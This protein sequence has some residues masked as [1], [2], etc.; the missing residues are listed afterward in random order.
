VK[1]IKVLLASGEGQNYFDILDDVP[2][3]E[4]VRASTRD[5]ILE[6]V[7]DVEVF[8]GPPSSELLAA[9]KALR[10]I[11]TP[12]AGVDVLMRLPE[13][14]ENDIVMTN[15]RGAHGPSIAEH[16]FALLLSLTRAIPACLE[17]QKQKHWG[18]GES[19]RALHEIKGSTLGIVGFGAIG[20]NVAQRATAFEMAILAVDAQPVVGPPLVDEVWP[21]SRLHELLAQSDVV[22]IAAPFT[23]ETRHLI[24]AAA[25][26]QMRSDAYLIAVSRG[27]IV[28][29]AALIEALRAGR[30]AGVG[31]DVSEQEPLSPESP[32][33]DFPNVII[34]PHVAGASA[35]KERR[36]VEIFRENLI[37]YTNGD[38]L[39]NLV[40]KRLG[41]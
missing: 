5:E 32:L 21:V 3:I 40:D 37:R 39:M 30:L 29:E 38:P 1:T 33:W 20:R 25:L 23:R 41:Y 9:A 17:W 4:I 8:Y 19:Y 14:V 16:V 10:W 31:L 2:G 11:Q 36:C 18:R 12:S 35:Q 6:R 7:G 27:G 26:A 24:D 34:T 28:D 13:L 22:V 15:T